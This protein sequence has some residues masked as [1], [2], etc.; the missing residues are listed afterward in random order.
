M[1]IL[2]FVVSLFWIL[3]AIAQAPVT[4]LENLKAQ[5]ETL[6]E[7]YKKIKVFDAWNFLGQGVLEFSTTTVGIID[8]GVDLAN[9]KH[10][11]FEGVTFAD[12]DKFARTDASELLGKSPSGHG[13][14][15][16]GIIGANNI[17]AT[18]SANYKFPQMNGIISGATD[19]YV[20]ELLS[21]VNIEFDIAFPLA[22]SAKKFGGRLNAISSNS[23]VNMSFGGSRCSAVG[24]ASP[25][26]SDDEFN[27]V[28][29]YYAEGIDG[30]SDILFIMS[31]GN[32]GIDTTSSTPSNIERENTLIVGATNLQDGR[33][34]FSPAS[35]SNFGVGIDL[36]APGE[37]VYAPSIREKGNFPTSVPQK[38]KNYEANFAG[39]S[40]AAPMITGV[41]AILKALET[42]YQNFTPGLEMNPETIKNVLVSSSDPIITDE[43]LGSG[44]FN[45][46]P[47]STGCRL[48]AHR[49]VAWFFPPASSTL[50]TSTITTSTIT[51][52]WQL[53]GDFDFFNPDFD[54]YRLFRST[55]SPATLDSAP[56]TTITTSS[57]LSFTDTNLP[58]NTQF[59]YKLFTFDKAE[60][61]SESNEASAITVP[62]I[63]PFDFA[64]D[65]FSI[66]GNIIGSGNPDGI[67]DFFD[68]FNDN[69]LDIP[70]TSQFFFTQGEAFTNESDGFLRFQSIDGT[71]IRSIGGG[72]FQ[73][74]D[75]AKTPS[76]FLDGQGNSTITAVYRADE[77]GEGRFY[78]LGLASQID[79]QQE[80]SIIFVSMV[81]IPAGTFVFA[82]DET[83]TFAGQQVDL[84]TTSRIHLRLQID[85]VLNAATFAFSLNGTTFTTLFILSNAIFILDPDVFSFMQGGVIF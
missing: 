1:F 18:S 5:D 20:L 64:V 54:S 6:V 16:T 11:E 26:I 80:A 51:L 4:D 71:F 62:D 3:F 36:S 32:K 85:D 30:R 59:F 12:G 21:I 82:G 75:D 66:D 50:S 61:S 38:E 19:K 2:L 35:S 14:L 48:N 69:R 79:P 72:Q 47:S 76:F 49:A 67:P 77:P 53:D 43:L 39:T 56:V 78:S 41:A 60:L 57:T 52:S 25:C 44:C 68:E 10:P 74:F 23:I 40:A 29:N 8:S 70:P 22:P 7:A 27:E 15:V 34:F 81:Q 37:Q 31:A 33:L 13:T 45:E 83:T 65:S 42:E 63:P 17:S 24:N 84:S 73:A 9:G 28:T 55:S 46:T 58:P